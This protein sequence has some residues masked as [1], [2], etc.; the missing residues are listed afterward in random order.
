MAKLKIFE[1]LERLLH[2][3]DRALQE[4]LLEIVSV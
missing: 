3:E 1:Y 4:E 2:I